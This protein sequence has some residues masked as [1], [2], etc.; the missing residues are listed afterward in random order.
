MLTTYETSFQKFDSSFWFR[1]DQTYIFCCSLSFV[2]LEWKYLFRCASRKKFCVFLKHSLMIC[3]IQII[4]YLSSYWNV[5]ISG[6]LSGIFANIYP[7]KQ[8]HIPVPDKFF[9]CH[10]TRRCR[11]IY[12][13]EMKIHVAGNLGKSVVNQ[14]AFPYNGRRKVHMEQR[15]K[16]LKDLNLLD[17]FYSH[18]RR[19]TQI[20]CVI[21][22]RSS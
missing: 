8:D 15:Q 9:Q 14:W 7:K 11:K 5:G 3:F 4:L 18:R 21:Y 13:A 22:W 12:V 10:A 17:R 1:I 19:T 16:P 2:V 6:S 20:L